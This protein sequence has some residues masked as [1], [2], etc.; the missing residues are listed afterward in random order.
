MR[1]EKAKFDDVFI[2]KP[3]IFEDSRGYF[4]ESY[5]QK[6]FNDLIGKK[7][8]FI[9][10]NES[11]SEYGVMRG[12]HFQ[13]PP[14]TQSKLIRVIKGAI[15]DVI[16][17][18]KSDSKTFGEMAIVKIDSNEKNQLFVPRGYAH[19]YVAV[20]DDTIIHYKV[21]NYYA[22]SFESGILFGSMEINFKEEIGHEE[23]ITSEKD[24]KLLS[25][26]DVP[27]F[28]TSEYYLNF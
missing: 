12:L 21:D 9:Q 15:I 11:Q 1:L 16:V 26:D 27:F 28:K 17:D 2:V 13:E 18:I 20:E 5:N 4:F 25:F 8:Q 10:D 19:G 14:Y 22:P 23:F 6:K 24:Q 3:N 7:H